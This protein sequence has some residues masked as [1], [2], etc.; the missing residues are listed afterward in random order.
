MLPLS[1]KQLLIGTVDGVGGFDTAHYN[2]LAAS[3]S[4]AYFEAA[5]NREE[6]RE[7]T[8]II[9]TNSTKVV[10]QL[11]LES[12]AEDSEAS[13]VVLVHKPGGQAISPREVTYPIVLDGVP[14]GFPSQ[15]VAARVKD[16]VDAVAKRTPLNR[17]DGVT[18]ASDYMRAVS[19]VDRGDE[20]LRPEQASPEGA[21]KAILVFREGVSKGRVVVPLATAHSLLENP[22]QPMNGA[23]YALTYLL[24]LVSAIEITDDAVPGLLGQS[25]EDSYEGW[26]YRYVHGALDSYLASRLSAQEGDST[27]LMKHYR[28]LME[29]QMRSATDAVIAAKVAYRESGDVSAVSETAL[30]AGGCILD[31][32]GRLL[33]TAHAF[34]LPPIEPGG[35]LSEH[36]ATAGLQQWLRTFSEDLQSLYERSGERSTIS[37]RFRFNRHAD[38]LLWSF[39]MAT[40]PLPN[41]GWWVH[42]S[43]T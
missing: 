9:G 36:V 37:D 17:L 11:A 4:R 16:I 24:A 26:R 27:E 19:L 23:R 28:D 42:V 32:A 7:L 20:R 40:W 1:S 2:E 3:C 25:I 43:G 6:F 18:F 12:L 5:E 33:G 30:W 8:K 13:V 29:A 21:G 39:G 31:A 15:A 10:D 22:T 14:D 34:K 38:R 41:G 35:S